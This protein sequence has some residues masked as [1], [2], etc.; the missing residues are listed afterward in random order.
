MSGRVGRQN[1]V[2]LIIVTVSWIFFRQGKLTTHKEEEVYPKNPYLQDFQSAEVR[3]YTLSPLTLAKTQVPLQRTKEKDH[4][5][6][7]WEGSLF[8]RTVMT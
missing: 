2:H 1:T 3:A 7:F 6:V 5:K 8:P 4:L